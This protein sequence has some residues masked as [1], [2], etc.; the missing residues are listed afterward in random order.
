MI[1]IPV[2]ILGLILYISGKR[3]E[4][5][6]IF[7]FFLFQGFQFIPE[8]W[9]ETGLGFSKSQ[10]FAFLYVAI[11]FIWGC[12]SY[13]DFIPKNKI[14]LCIA[15]YLVFIVFLIL[16]SK[17][18]YQIDTG[19]IIRTSRYYFFVLAYYIFRRLS[20]EEISLL[21]KILFYIT[22]FQCIL[23]I[24][25]AFTGIA[26]L[27]GAENHKTGIITRFYNAPKMMYFLVFYA[28]FANPFQGKLKYVST[29]II[30]TTLFLPMTRS[31]SMVFVLCLFI[32][33]YYF[34]GGAKR[35]I[36]YLPIVLVIFLPLFVAVAAL[37]AGRTVS[38]IQSVVNGEFVEAED[39][40]LTQESTFLFRMAHT[41][42]RYLY[43]EEKTERLLF[44]AGLM[45]ED[46]KYTDKKFDFVIGLTNEKK[47]T[48]VQLDTADTSW[49]NFLIRYGIVGT[50][51]YLFLYVSLTLYFYKNR[52]NEWGLPVFLY[53][54]L[55]LGVSF[56]SDL[57][58][59]VYV[60]VF[61]LMLYD[62]IINNIKEND[63][64]NSAN[65]IV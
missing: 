44:G 13:G 48:P 10:D 62:H 50:V 65:F 61:P 26:L 56:T 15:I 45:A 39:V 58:Y 52:K 53:L 4:S 32:G 40:E 21:L 64:G 3:L 38:D 2:L 33:T 36:K 51:L 30:V 24:I 42:E 14:T 18:Y 12:F 59:Q 57:F 19:D 25:Q 16:Y 27:V 22:L 6:L 46:S 31:L 49:S 60:L 28:V 1:F 7:C 34:L 55:L 11:L 41:Y 23:F 63:K 29:F 20:T 8:T 43:M 47:G 35:F 9:F 17:F 37:M 54:L 5:S